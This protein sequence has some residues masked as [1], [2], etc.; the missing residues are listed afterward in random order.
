VVE[1]E[2]AL[3]LYLKIAEYLDIELNHL[4]NLSD[5]INFSYNKH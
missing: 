3:N 5:L 2:K 1:S 4:N